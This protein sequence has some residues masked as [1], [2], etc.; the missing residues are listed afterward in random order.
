MGSDPTPQVTQYVLSAEDLKVLLSGFVEAS[1]GAAAAPSTTDAMTALLKQVESLTQTAQRSIRYENP[2]YEDVSVFTIDP[3][4]EL[5]KTGGLHFLPDDPIGKKAHPRPVMRY[6]FEF[7]YGI[8]RPEWLTIPE[9][10]L[11]NQ[12][13]GDKTARNGTWTATISRQGT[14]QKLIIDVPYRG[15]DTRHDLPSLPA[16]LVELIYGESVADPSQAVALIQ[17]LQKKV[18]ELEARL[19]SSASA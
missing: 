12:F 16:I 7:C 10:Q 18:D 13:T 4:C 15:L 14:K 6:D 3:Q 11:V 8:V 5:C 19:A 1:K 9:I 17:A 2:H